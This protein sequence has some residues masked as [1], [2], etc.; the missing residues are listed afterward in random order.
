ME[1]KV[2]FKNIKCF[3]IEL[4]N[5]YSNKPSFFS[6]KRVESGI[7]FIIA[8]W[9][10]I[11]FLLEN[12]TTMGMGGFALWASIQFFVAGYM[13]NQI[14]KEKSKITS[15]DSVNDQI[16]DSVTQQEEEDK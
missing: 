8:E 14:Q 11:F 10:I 2:R 16:T 12:I 5:V 3:F 7:G 9:G 1:K 4:L 15:D 6:K 13:V